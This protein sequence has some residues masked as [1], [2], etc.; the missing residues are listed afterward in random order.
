MKF[1]N[2]KGYGNR[3]QRCELC[4]AVIFGK[5]FH[6]VRSTGALRG[7]GKSLCNKCFGVLLKMPAGQ[8]L[9]ALNDA[10]GKLSKS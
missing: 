10:A 9:A 7:K 4:N 6:D 3:E 8:A 2:N 5:T 1:S